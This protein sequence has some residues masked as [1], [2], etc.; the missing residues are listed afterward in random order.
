LV[1]L[2]KSLQR[3]NML[4]KLRF[5]GANLHCRDYTLPEEIISTCK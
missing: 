1:D 5:Q 2:E 3:Y 4:T